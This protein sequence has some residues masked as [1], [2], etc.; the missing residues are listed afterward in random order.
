MFK[1]L[2][3]PIKLND[4]EAWEAAFEAGCRI[5]KHH[6]STLT[7]ATIMPEWVTVKSGDYSW[8][9]KKWFEMRA[10]TALDTLKAKAGCRNCR[11]LAHWGS[12]PGSILDIAMQVDA[13]LIVLPAKMPRLIDY[14][15]KPT[16]LR[17]AG[18]APCSVLLVRA[19]SRPQYEDKG[20]SYVQ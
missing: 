18:R 2:L 19:G 16:A 17:L 4:A 11:T 14:L 6:D 15:S 5:A 7:L 1:S 13:D 10:A 20:R 8:E 3:V 12:V 9:A